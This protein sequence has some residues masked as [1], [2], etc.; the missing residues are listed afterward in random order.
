MSRFTVDTWEIIIEDPTIRE[1]FIKRLVRLEN[2]DGSLHSYTFSKNGI[3]WHRKPS[4]IKLIID[5]VKH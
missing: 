3:A 2:T 1:V 5:L 4:L